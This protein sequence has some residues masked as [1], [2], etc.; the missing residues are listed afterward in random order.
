MIKLS[1]KIDLSLG[2]I[3]LGVA[4]I[5]VA[6][7][8]YKIFSPDENE[9]VSCLTDEDVYPSDL[10][11]NEL[12][13]KG[14]NLSVKPALSISKKVTSVVK[15]NVDDFKKQKVIFDTKKQSVETK[16][17]TSHKSLNLLGSVEKIDNN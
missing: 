5:S 8:A 17:S 10:N 15:T 6:V 1:M 2:K 3:L 7:Y 16:S 14:E 12:N 9:E 13:E 11:Q 4:G